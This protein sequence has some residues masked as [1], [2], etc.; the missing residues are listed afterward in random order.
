MEIKDNTLIVG[1]D[2]AKNE[3]WARFV[4]YRGIEVGK[5]VK[6]QNDLQGFERI[7]AIIE[8]MCN[9]ETQYSATDV[10]IEM[11]PTGHYWKPLAIYLSNIGYKVTGVNPFHT[12]KAKEL[13]DNSQTKSDFKDALTIAK[14]VAEGRYFDPYLPE[15]IYGDLR[16]LTNERVSMKKRRSSVK[17]TIIAILDEYFPEIYTVFKSPLSGK[18]SRQILR[19]CPFPECILAMREEDILAEI[20][21]VTNR[22]VGIKKVKELIAAAKDSIGVENGQIAAKNRLR[23]LINELDQYEE[24]ME[25]IEQEMKEALY[26]TG[27]ADQLLNIKGVGVVTIASF[28]GEVGDPLRFTSARQIHNYA[29][30]NLVEDSSGKSKSGT[31]ISKRGRSQLRALLYQMAFT[32]V[33]QN[34]EMKELYT[35]LITRKDNPLK[36]KQALVVIAKKIVTVMHSILKNNDVYRPELVLGAVRQEMILAA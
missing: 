29:G 9:K 17:N 4:T 22:A 19:T 7:V 1:I 36:R 21:K 24:Q 13:D 8:E 10:I 31:K 35:Y 15:G 16:V 5:A 23:R 30:F 11:E 28:L 2:V 3:Q 20:K 25:E 33:G 12:K 14:L 27:Y 18:A 34:S 26:V 6:F 32:L